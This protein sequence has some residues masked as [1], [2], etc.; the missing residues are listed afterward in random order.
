MSARAI[1]KIIFLVVATILALIAVIIGKVIISG[2]AGRGNS[3]DYNIRK[4]MRIRIFC[5]IGMLIL[6]LICFL[7]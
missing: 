6:L 5:F 1:V 4:I 7:I 2:K 3:R